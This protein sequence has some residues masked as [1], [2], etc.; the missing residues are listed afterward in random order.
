MHPRIWNP[1]T[2]TLLLGALLALPDFGIGVVGAV[3]AGL[4]A[5]AHWLRRY[6]PK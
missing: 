2:V 5:L 1:V 4:W 3:A 6:E